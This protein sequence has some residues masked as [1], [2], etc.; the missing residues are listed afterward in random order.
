[1]SA[2]AIVADDK[3]V[4]VAVALNAAFDFVQQMP[5]GCVWFFFIQS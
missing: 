1:M 3:A 5:L 2:L 4:A